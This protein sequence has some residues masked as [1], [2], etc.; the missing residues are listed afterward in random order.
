M[1]A[2]DLEY[3]LN[4]F[5]VEDVGCERL[6]CDDPLPAHGAAVARVSVG[7]AACAHVQR[8]AV[9]CEPCL[10]VLAGL[11]DSR[12]PWCARSSRLVALSLLPVG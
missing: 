7:W 12:C 9:R 8:R 2:T 6:V 3:V 11:G 1:I 4:G 5:A 10:A